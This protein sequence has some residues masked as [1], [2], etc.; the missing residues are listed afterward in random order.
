[1]REQPPK[2]VWLIFVKAGQCLRR[3]KNMLDLLIKLQ[4]LFDNGFVLVGFFGFIN[5]KN[6]SMN[7]YM[8]AY[9]L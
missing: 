5:R 6:L 3:Q 4:F 1:M 8:L 9:I 2:R 7:L